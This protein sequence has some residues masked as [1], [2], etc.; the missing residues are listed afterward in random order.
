M[1]KAFGFALLMTLLGLPGVVLL[2]VGITKVVRLR[3]FLSHARPVTGHVVALTH[4]RSHEDGDTYRLEVEYPSPSVTSRRFAVDT[5]NPHYVAGREIDDA[6]GTVPPPTAAVLGTTGVGALAR[7][8]PRDRS[9]TRRR[10]LPGPVW[11][12]GPTALGHARTWRRGPTTTP[13]DSPGDELGTDWAC[14]SDRAVEKPGITRTILIV[15]RS[16]LRRCCPRP[17]ERRNF[18]PVSDW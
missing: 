15:Q 17:G 18:A 7:V 10:P 6:H 13:V 2:V 3:D 9:P 8:P 4:L 16:D 14:R 1:R 11:P 12:G 5:G